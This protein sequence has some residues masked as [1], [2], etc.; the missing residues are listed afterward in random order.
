MSACQ[1]LPPDINE[2]A[3]MSRAMDKMEAEQAQSDVAR[4]AANARAETEAAKI[5]AGGIAQEKQTRK[6]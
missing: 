4:A 1:D 3:R 5:K 2:K 6:D